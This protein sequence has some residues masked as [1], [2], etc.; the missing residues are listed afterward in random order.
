MGVWT[1]LV[2]VR[3]DL[4]L[5]GKWW[6]HV[7]VGLG[8]FSALLVY[9]IVAGAVVRRPLKLTTA[10]TFS[11]TLLHEATAPSRQKTTTL[12]DLDALGIVGS[13]GSNGDLIPL[14]RPAGADIRCE[15]QAR[16]KASETIKIGDVAYQAIPD[17]PEQSSGDSRHCVATAAYAGV[18]A[19]S[20]AV[21]KP[22]GTGGRKLAAQAFLAGVAAM[23]VWLVLYWNVYYRGLM[24]FYAKRRQ[25]RKRRHFER[26]GVR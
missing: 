11:E 19:D 1:E 23:M 6:H 14:A 21:Y 3:K 7:A 10:N 16:F 2:G 26:Q 25:M 8:V 13:A 17:H 18:S 24:P 22:D 5:R 4:R 20:V 15:N 9:L 12:G